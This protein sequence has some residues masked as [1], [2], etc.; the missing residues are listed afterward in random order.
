MS[1]FSAQVAWSPSPDKDEVAYITGTPIE[2][3][4][5]FL[6]K[7]VSILDVE[8]V[9]PRKIYGD[10]GW[11]IQWTEQD[12]MSLY[13]WDLG[14]KDPRVFRFNNSSRQPRG[15]EETS[16]RS[17]HFS[18]SHKYYF[19]PSVE[20]DLFGI[21]ETTTDQDLTT[22]NWTS[23]DKHT[24]NNIRNSFLRSQ[25]MQY[26]Q[27]RGW[28]NDHILVVPFYDSGEQLSEF[29]YDFEANTC[30]FLNGVVIDISGQY[31]LVLDT[32]R[33]QINQIQVGQFGKCYQ[34]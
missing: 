1:R 21:L 31:I 8:D 23:T 27:P 26:A 2:S 6:S 28:I 18:P 24:E 20:G 30:H 10:G 22:I 5:G 13:I 12:Q 9:E 25:Q 29:I 4:L 7:G 15:L 32:S 16:H 11:D 19:H 34:Q 14:S 17:I 3:G 33:N